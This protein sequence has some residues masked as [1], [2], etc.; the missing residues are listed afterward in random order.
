MPLSVDANEQDNVEFRCS[1]KDKDNAHTSWFI[2]GESISKL[3]LDPSWVVNKYSLIIS[4]VTAEDIQVIQ[5]NISSHHGYI[6][7]NA[8]LN[9]NIKP[10]IQVKAL[11]D[12]VEGAT[13]VLAWKIIGHPKPNVYWMKGNVII[14]ENARFRV[15]TD[16]FLR[17]FNV[18]TEDAGLYTCTAK[19]T[20]GKMSARGSLV[21]ISP[22]VAVNKQDRVYNKRE[23]TVKSPDNTE[24]KTENL[25]K[26]SNK[27][28][29]MNS[30]GFEV[31][32]TNIFY[33]SFLAF[34][35]KFLL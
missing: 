8:Y 11:Q 16:G 28:I 5:C 15:T 32:V 34:F 13:A 1:P 25:P 12:V 17:I 20:A 2:N 26:K 4:N 10:R 6:F 29:Y 9:V 24:T 21:V 19:N 3:D 23:S 30:G 14:S 7:A 33:M 22:S 35:S 27:K 31:E 18:S